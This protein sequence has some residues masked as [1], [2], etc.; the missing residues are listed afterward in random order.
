[1]FESEIKWNEIDLFKNVYLIRLKFL[2]KC[3]LKEA[4]FG[5]FGTFQWFRIMVGSHRSVPC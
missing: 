3:V 2:L 4:L 1:M 5:N